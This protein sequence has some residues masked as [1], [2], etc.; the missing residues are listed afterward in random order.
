MTS[1]SVECL[2]T[3][4]AHTTQDVTDLRNYTIR[5]GGEDPKLDI[6][7]AFVCLGHGTLLLNLGGKQTAL[8]VE[9]YARGP[10]GHD[11]CVSAW[12]A[13]S[14][15]E[16]FVPGAPARDNGRVR[17]GALST[18][19]Q[20]AKRVFKDSHGEAILLGPAAGY[21]KHFAYNPPRG[22][23]SSGLRGARG[24]GGRIKCRIQKYH[25]VSQRFCSEQECSPLSRQIFPI[26][27]SN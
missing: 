4:S 13:M 21:G 20:H 25:E 3:P 1:T 5:C 9:G 23:A 17:S 16:K 14:R 15:G 12:T 27:V 22:T 11:C 8:K 7:H 26:S 24:G 2:V 6:R 19:E 10:L 18:I